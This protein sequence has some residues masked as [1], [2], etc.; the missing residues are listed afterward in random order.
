V[1]ITD[2]EEREVVTSFSECGARDALAR[3]LL[4]YVKS[5]F[6]VSGPAGKELRLNFASEWWARPDDDALYPSAVVR[7]DDR[8]TLDDPSTTP[9]VKPV[10]TREGEWV[11]E[12]AEYV[13]T[14]RLEIRTSDPEARTGF[15]ALLEGALAHPND[16]MY[17]LRIM[18]P[19]YF[20]R[21]AEYEP[22]QDSYEDDAD[23]ASTLHR[24]HVW[25][26]TARV[27]LTRPRSFAQIRAKQRT[28]VE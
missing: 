4:D 12:S 7:A 11:M 27:P 20:G 19:F 16:W 24:V 18:L 21:H 5:L 23:A 3:G 15:A 14:L 28:A 1:L 10:R 8:G 17:G 22:V 9:R 13:T 25:L 6:P 2:P 26:F